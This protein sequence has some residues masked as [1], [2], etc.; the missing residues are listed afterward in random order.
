MSEFGDSFLLAPFREF[1]AEVIRLKRKVGAESWMALPAAASGAD[2]S[3]DE[4]SVES[5]TWLYVPHLTAEAGEGNGAEHVI[6]TSPVMPDKET[7]L[8][9][10]EW[11]SNG[12]VRNFEEQYYSPDSAKI[13]SEVWHSLLSLFRTQANN[14]WRYGG[15]HGAQLYQKAWYV[16]VALADEIFVHTEWEGQKAWNLHL[17]ESKIFRTHDAGQ[18]FFEQLDSLLRTQNPADRDLAAVYLMAL[19]LGFKGKY[20]DSRDGKRQL[21][22]YRKRLFAFICQ[23]EPELGDETRPLFPEAYLH[24]A[25]EEGQRKLSDPRAWVVVLCLVIVI[26][27]VATQLF[28]L[29]LTRELN[30]IN[31]SIS[32]T[33]GYL[34]ARP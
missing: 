10:V 14:A 19:S 20:Y 22:N 23:R 30:M 27:T 26:Y 6:D 32:T 4:G 17:L 16:M 15:A 12:A 8:T 7:A 5:G 3:L 18:R 13:S 29:Q 24:L 33:I 9:L 28:W 31:Q 25:R 34:K 2:A 11:S 1:Y 21:A